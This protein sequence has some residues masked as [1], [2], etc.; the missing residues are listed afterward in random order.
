M[1]GGVGMGEE[2]RRRGVEEKGTQE[3]LNEHAPISGA[4]VLAGGSFSTSLFTLFMSFGVTTKSS[5]P[6]FFAA[7]ASKSLSR[8]TSSMV[9]WKM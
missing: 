8:S 7:F 4:F 3:R 5:W 6:S 1:E 9:F 2:G